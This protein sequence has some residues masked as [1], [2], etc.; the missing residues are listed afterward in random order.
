MVRLTVL[1]RNPLTATQWIDRGSVDVNA[2]NGCDAESRIPSA[3][4]STERPNVD[5]FAMGVSTKSWDAAARDLRLV[6]RHRGWGGTENKKANEWTGQV[7]REK[8]MLE[9]ADWEQETG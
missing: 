3:S 7:G 9:S 6:V 2:S 1:S 8:R 5:E 4:D